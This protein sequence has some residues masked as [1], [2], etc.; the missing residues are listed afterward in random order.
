MTEASRA[1]DFDKW[2]EDLVCPVCFGALRFSDTAVVCASC[3]GSYPVVDGIPVLIVERS[4]Q[5]K[6]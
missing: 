3:E 1:T 2:A 4:S 6:S 5:K